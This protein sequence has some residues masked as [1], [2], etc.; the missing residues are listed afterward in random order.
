[1]LIFLSYRVSC[2]LGLLAKVINR[3]PHRT[4]EEPS[5]EVIAKAVKSFPLSL[6]LFSYNFKECG[7][8]G[9]WKLSI[10]FFDHDPYFIPLCPC[11]PAAASSRLLLP[12]ALVSVKAGA[13]A[14]FW[15]SVSGAH[16]LQW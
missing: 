14:S 15:P 4:V 6:P 10:L 13:G 12:M 8:L 3:S 9:V 5:K 11:S 2:Q 1:M 16:H 7:H